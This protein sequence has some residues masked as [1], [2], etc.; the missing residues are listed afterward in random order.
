MLRL[1]P[2]DIRLKDSRKPSTTDS[3]PLPFMAARAPAVSRRDSTTC[4]RSRKRLMSSAC[5]VASAVPRLTAPLRSA[6]SYWKTGMA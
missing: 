4:P 5:S 6:I 2:L 3:I 1:T